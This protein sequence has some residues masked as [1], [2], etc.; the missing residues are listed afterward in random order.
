MRFALLLISSWFPKGSRSA[1]M[2]TQFDTQSTLKA[3]PKKGQSSHKQMQ[4]WKGGEHH[5]GRGTHLERTAKR[6]AKTLF[7]NPLQ[8]SQKR[9]VVASMRPRFQLGMKATDSFPKLRARKIQ[10]GRGGSFQTGCHG[11]HP[12][13]HDGIIQ[14]TKARNGVGSLICTQKACRNIFL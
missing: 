2:L 5:R 4:P 9:A 14:G 13:G 3:P 8:I 7:S 6:C 12:R 1:L 11:Q 10:H